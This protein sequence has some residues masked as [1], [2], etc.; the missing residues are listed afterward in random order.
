MKWRQWHLVIASSHCLKMPLFCDVT[1]TQYRGGCECVSI[2]MHQSV[3]IQYMCINQCESIN[4]C[5]NQCASI[6][7]YKS[8]CINQCVSINVYQ[9]MC[10]SISVY[11]YVYQYTLSVV[12]IS[13]YICNDIAKL[14]KQ[15]YI[16]NCQCIPGWSLHLSTSDKLLHMLNYSLG[17]L[18]DWYFR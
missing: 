17:K 1:M 6:D 15:A 12:L 9:S 14:G 8:V 16:V 18:G 4:V 10:T 5:I 11:Q 2:S 13:W 7:V 3:C